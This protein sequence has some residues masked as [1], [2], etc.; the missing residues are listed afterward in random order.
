MRL[1]PDD[2]VL[3]APP[4]FWSYGAANALPATL[5]HGATLVLQD[6]FEP[7]EW[8]GLIERRRL[9]PAEHDR[10]GVAASRIPSRTRQK[11][12]HRA[13]D[14]LARGGP[15]RRRGTRRRS[16]L[17]HLRRDRNLRQL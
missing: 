10:R 13:D 7:G 16:N 5:T 8:L 12:A 2:R 3:L 6:R 4:L 15:G 14:R 17:Q 9:H 1:G 11:P